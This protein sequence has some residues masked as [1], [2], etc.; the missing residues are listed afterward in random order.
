MAVIT[1]HCVSSS[2]YHYYKKSEKNLQTIRSAMPWRHMQMIA[3]KN[4]LSRKLLQKLC[5]F[6]RTW[7]TLPT[8]IPKAEVFSIDWFILAPSAQL[9]GVLPGFYHLVL[10]PQPHCHGDNHLTQPKVWLSDTELWLWGGGWCGK[11][12][13]ISPLGKV[14][15]SNWE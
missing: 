5:T 4:C 1:W 14:K 13:C 9:G 7:F 15:L 11:I 12:I 8:F 2:V 3:L 6:Q 10:S